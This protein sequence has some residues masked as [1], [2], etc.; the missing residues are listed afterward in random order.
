[1]LWYRCR[2][3]EETLPDISPGTTNHV[4]LER[5]DSSNGSFIYSHCVLYSVVVG[6]A[7][8]QHSMATIAWSSLHPLLLSP[9][10]PG[11][12]PNRLNSQEEQGPY[13]TLTISLFPSTTIPLW[14]RHR[15]WLHCWPHLALCSTLEALLE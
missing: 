4:S 13:I 11:S 1:M 8:A 15:V 14:L 10:L 2:H 12:I 6:L 7:V 5:T 9:S 3:P